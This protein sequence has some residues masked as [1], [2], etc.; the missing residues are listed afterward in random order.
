MCSRPRA[1]GGFVT[2]LPGRKFQHSFY[3][4]VSRV[5]SNCPERNYGQTWLAASHCGVAVPDFD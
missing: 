3:Q 2:A 1:S 5:F 4:T